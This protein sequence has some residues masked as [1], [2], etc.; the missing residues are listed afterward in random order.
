MNVESPSTTASEP[1]LQRNSLMQSPTQASPIEVEDPQDTSEVSHTRSVYNNNESA[2]IPTER[3]EAPHFLSYNTPSSED[4][5]PVAGSE[6]MPDNLQFPFPNDHGI[7][8]G[9]NDEDDENWLETIPLPQSEEP[10]FDQMILENEGPEDKGAEDKGVEV[11][12]FD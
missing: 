10:D 11:E 8:T 2:N 5:K 7:Q 9:V 3:P 6:E 1:E 12:D 4:A